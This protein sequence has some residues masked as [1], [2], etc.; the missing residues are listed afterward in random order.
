MTPATGHQLLVLC[1]HIVLWR[2]KCVSKY[3]CQTVNVYNEI[4]CFA[5]PEKRGENLYRSTYMICDF[6]AFGVKEET[7]G[8]GGAG[9]PRYLNVTDLCRVYSAS[10]L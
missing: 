2:T 6:Y 5:L 3:T 1:M 10:T 7:M 8:I 9:W 4:N